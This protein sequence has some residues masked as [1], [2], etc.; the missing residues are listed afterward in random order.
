MAETA[1]SFLSDTLG[2]LIR[3]LVTLGLEVVA[4][5]NRAI[6]LPRLLDVRSKASRRMFCLPSVQ[7]RTV[8]DA[9]RIL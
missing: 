4:R 5:N 1:M 8:Q 6:H 7:I 9:P 3:D 2:H